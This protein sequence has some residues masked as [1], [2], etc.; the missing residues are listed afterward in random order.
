M[1]LGLEDRRGHQLN[2]SRVRWQL[3]PDSH[4]L[5]ALYNVRGSGGRGIV[6]HLDR[7]PCM[8][9]PW[10]ER[11]GQLK[12]ALCW[13]H[14]ICDLRPI[15]YPTICI[16]STQCV[17]WIWKAPDNVTEYLEIALCHLGWPPESL[18][19]FIASMPE[20][21]HQLGIAFEALD[22]TDDLGRF[23]W[24]KIQRC[25]AGNLWETRHIATQH[26]LSK[27]HGLEYRYPSALV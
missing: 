5:A 16:D 18:E 8:R 6:L 22:G 21:R 19:A 26:R 20:M 7:H 14:T 4:C 17:A 9:P 12:V 25:V 11:E 24:I 10:W 27:S 1:G 15:T 3:L 23:P 2:V 13:A